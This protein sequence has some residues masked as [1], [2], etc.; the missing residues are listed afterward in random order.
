[1]IVFIAALFIIDKNMEAKAM[2]S[3]I[4]NWGYINK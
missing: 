3:A 2:P 4:N 1:M